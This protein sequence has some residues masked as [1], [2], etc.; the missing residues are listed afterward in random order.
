MSIP[1][2]PANTRL[3]FININGIN[4]D[5]QAVQF[6]DLCTKMKKAEIHIMAIAEHNLDTEKFA[7]RQLL[8]KNAQRTFPHH[9]LQTSTSSIPANKFYKPGGTMLLAQGDVV[10]RIN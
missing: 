8:E 6:R 4:L 10:G 9:V 1:I 7:V 3:Y 5:K 2:D